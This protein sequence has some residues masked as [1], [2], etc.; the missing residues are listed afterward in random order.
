MQRVFGQ[1][2]IILP[3]LNVVKQ[4]YQNREA[5]HK[6]GQFIFIE[7]GCPWKCHLY[8]I[9]ADNNQKGLI[10]F[11]FFVDSKKMYRI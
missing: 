11:A 3:A 4:A 10:K 7:Q 2:T 1:V 9:E 6:S 8:E 5:F